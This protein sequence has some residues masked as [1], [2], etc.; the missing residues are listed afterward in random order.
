[1]AP[2]PAAASDGPSVKPDSVRQSQALLQERIVCGQ[3]LLQR[4]RRKVTALILV[5][6]L[7]SVCYTGVG[8]HFCLKWYWN[9][10]RCANASWGMRLV[11]STVAFAWTLRVALLF[12]L[13]SANAN[14]LWATRIVL[15][16]EATTLGAGLFVQWLSNHAFSWV[17][18]VHGLFIAV[19]AA[20]VL[21][22]SAERMRTIL[23]TFFGAWV[24]MWFVWDLW[25]WH[26]MA[27]FCR[28][29]DPKGIWWLPLGPPEFAV[30]YAL[31]MA[32][33][34][35]PSWRR[36]VEGRIS[37][38]FEA[39][40]STRSAACV[41]G[42]VGDSTAKEA[43]AQASQRFR[44]ISFQLL[45]PCA[46]AD[47][48]PG[49]DMFGRTLSERLHNCDA[50]IS[51]SWHDSAAE[52]WAAMQRWRDGFLT[53]ESREPTIWFDKCCI[54]QRKIEADLRCLPVFLSGCRRLVVFCGPTYLKR[55]WCILELFIFVHCGRKVEDLTFVPVV[56]S[57]YEEED[58]MNLETA[59]ANFDVAQCTCFIK[60]ERERLLGIIMSS[61]GDLDTF[62]SAVRSIFKRAGW[63]TEL[64]LMRT[65]TEGFHQWGSSESL[66]V[67]V[68]EDASH[69][70]ES[71][72]NGDE[73]GSAIGADWCSPLSGP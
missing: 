21:C 8:A 48:E 6:Y 55:L 67:K 44:T 54:D 22:R 23:W 2:S 62:N 25:Y 68:D 53:L 38:L 26:R 39:E 66:S 33:A 28:Q 5:M 18:V 29:R 31:G 34:G 70:N 3:D 56:R 15:T 69:A 64:R 43:L 49:G 52:K 46:I 45:D 35:R 65:K 32:I 40:S 14:S 30:A 13:P 12:L 50:F 19:L 41:A 4:I 58:L 36:A 72:W 17:L 9:G 60:R 63:A 59:F 11:G 73:I 24:A 20:A 37:L 47:S 71:S 27:N 42:L 7:L 57:G 51:H 61:Y 10:H 16:C 1:M